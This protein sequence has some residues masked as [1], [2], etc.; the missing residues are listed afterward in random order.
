MATGP[1]DKHPGDRAARA[2]KCAWRKL[3]LRFQYQ[4]ER[5]LRRAPKSCKACLRKYVS[6]PH[7]AG[8]SSEP[9]AHVLR[10]G[11]RRADHRR[12]CVVQAS[13]WRRILGESVAGEWLHQEHGAFI[14]QRLSRVAGSSDGV[15]HVMQT[16]EEA[17][18]IKVPLGVL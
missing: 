8:L 12:R 14:L 1:D 3:L 7:F 4:V 18:Q 6:E 15:A 2:A 10:Q 13:N 16:V 5:R 11:V 17:D 9:E